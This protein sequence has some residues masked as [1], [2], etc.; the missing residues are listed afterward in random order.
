MA[1]QAI[2]Y[3][4]RGIAPLLLAFVLVVSQSLAAYGAMPCCPENITSPEK[5]YPDAHAHGDSAEPHSHDGQDSGH[6]GD[7]AGA[8]ACDTVCCGTCMPFMDFEFSSAVKSPSYGLATDLAD[9]EQV[10]DPRADWVTPPPK[11]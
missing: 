5:A 9:D 1:M 2:A 4:N 7:Q 10:V 3:I 6:T 8:N 11:K